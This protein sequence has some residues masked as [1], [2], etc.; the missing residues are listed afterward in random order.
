M[1][2][3]P[4]LGPL[5][6][7]D[8]AKADAKRAARAG[9]AKSERFGCP[10]TPARPKHDLR[11]GSNLRPVAIDVPHPGT[12]APRGSARLATRSRL[13]V[14]GWCYSNMYSNG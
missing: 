10:R 1:S 8:E 14:S 5:I 13:Q 2:S 6:L 7:E 12:G 3:G 9:C 11:A 4:N